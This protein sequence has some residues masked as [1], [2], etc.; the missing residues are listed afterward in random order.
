VTN[1]RLA[2]FAF[3]I[4]YSSL[5][6]QTVH[7]AKP[8]DLAYFSNPKAQTARLCPWIAAHPEGWVA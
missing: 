1:E 2:S 7:Q 5:L 4:S 6:K 3:V 8:P